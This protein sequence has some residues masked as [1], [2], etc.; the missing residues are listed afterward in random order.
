M[1]SKPR[2]AR[3]GLDRSDS[4]RHTPQETRAQTAARQCVPPR[5]QGGHRHPAQFPPISDRKNRRIR[6]RIPRSSPQVR[7]PL[8]AC[9]SWVAVAF[10]VALR[11]L[12][13]VAFAVPRPAARPARV[14]GIG[15]GIYSGLCVQCRTK[16]TP[17]G[18]RNDLG[19]HGHDLPA[20][21]ELSQ[22]RPCFR[23][24]NAGDACDAH[25]SRSRRGLVATTPWRCAIG[26]WVALA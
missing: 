4:G 3:S 11:M 20:R 2:V 6:S 8:G 23:R 5:G 25:P 14:H 10:S 22:P 9:S 12:H 7:R 17:S 26:G 16:A 18:S 24:P 15:C 1:W 21:R 19:R 13:P